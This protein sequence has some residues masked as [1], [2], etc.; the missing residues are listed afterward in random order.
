MLNFFKKGEK[1][2]IRNLK[3]ILLMSGVSLLA[4]C[5][6]FT[7]H[8]ERGE[9]AKKQ[10]SEY[11]EEHKAQ[12]NRKASTIYVKSLP[13]KEYIVNSALKHD[14]PRE[15]YVLAGIESDFRN[16]VKGDNGAYGMWQITPSFAKDLNLSHTDL[17]DWKKTTDALMAYLKSNGDKNFDGKV[18]LSVLAHN[19]GTGSVK[20]LMAK[21]QT[22][23]IWVILED[24][25]LKP[26]TKEYMYQYINYS[27]RFK[28]IK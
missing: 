22:N 1:M 27:E 24:K 12:L 26:Y 9:K 28:K 19:I 6:S 4:A 23:D 10:Y 14:M 2:L 15:I 17:N 8:H 16:D 7:I 20:K 25:K 5:S 21:N 18:E 13:Y 3:T 11:V